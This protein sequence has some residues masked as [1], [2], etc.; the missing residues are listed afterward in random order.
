MEDRS[1]LY[2]LLLRLHDHRLSHICR[3]GHA[4][5][6]LLEHWSAGGHRKSRATSKITKACGVAGLT[7]SVQDYYQMENGTI[8]DDLIV[9]T[10][11]E[12]DKINPNLLI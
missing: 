5:W 10:N 9:T 7:T 6:G 8:V 11:N 1:Y 4:G 12:P 2:W 3:I